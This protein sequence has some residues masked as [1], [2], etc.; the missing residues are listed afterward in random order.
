MPRL[1][2]S[3]VLDPLPAHTPTHTHRVLRTDTPCHADCAGKDP[4]SSATE[5]PCTSRSP[6]QTP[7]HGTCTSALCRRTT[8]TKAESRDAGTNRALQTAAHL[9]AAPAPAESPSASR[10]TCAC[11]RALRCASPDTSRCK[12]ASPQVRWWM[13]SPYSWSLRP[14]IPPA[15]QSHRQVQN[16]LTLTQ[17][18]APFEP[19]FASRFSSISCPKN[20]PL[21][22]P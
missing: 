3:P 21:A 9:H 6:A 22:T 12:S 19:R 5:S 10:S 11:P 17:K 1:P 7:S 8:R 18:T 4:P 15:F 14:T 20:R 16:C 13:R 2:P